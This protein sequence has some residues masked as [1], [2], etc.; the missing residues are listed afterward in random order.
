MDF[1]WLMLVNNCGIYIC[2]ESINFQIG[3]KTT[4]LNW[5]VWKNFFEQQTCLDK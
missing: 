5:D 1:L 4:E 3:N 2:S